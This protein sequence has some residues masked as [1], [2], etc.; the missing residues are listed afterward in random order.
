MKHLSIINCI[1][2]MNSHS[3]ILFKS[4]CRRYSVIIVAV[5][6]VDNTVVCEE[7]SRSGRQAKVGPLSGGGS[8]SAICFT[9]QLVFA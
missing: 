3:A 6:A 2:H 9:K 7:T 8:N 1:C 4:F 5:G